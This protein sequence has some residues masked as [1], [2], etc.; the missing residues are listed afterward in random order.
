MEQEHGEVCDE[1]QGRECLL[2]VMYLG[3][4]KLDK[5]HPSKSCTIWSVE[6]RYLTVVFAYTY[7]KA[8]ESRLQACRDL[9]NPL[10]N[11]SPTK[12]SSP[13]KEFFLT[14]PQKSPEK[15]PEKDVL[16]ELPRRPISRPQSQLSNYSER[17]RSLPTPRTPSG[18]RRLT[19]GRP[20]SRQ[21][22]H[23]IEDGDITITLEN[24]A[25]ITPRRPRRSEHHRTLSAI[26]RPDSRISVH[27]AQED[28]GRTTPFKRPESA[29]SARRQS[30]IPTP[31]E[32]RTSGIPAPRRQSGIPT[33]RPSSPTRSTSSS[34]F[35]SDTIT[36]PTISNAVITN[37]SMAAPSLISTFARRQSG[38][39][40][41]LKPRSSIPAPRKSG[42]GIP[43]PR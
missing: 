41:I 8:L 19:F 17:Y 33:P 37:G 32:R 25:N 31:S 43:L 9:V 40:T 15:S 29:M 38:A 26:T 16:A 18:S 21:S 13:T 10:L 14:S 30:G 4:V 1:E 39:T 7:E 28:D 36:S 2:Q 24:S 34:S 5:L 42:S 23:E 11:S 12:D 3:Q 6:S 20:Q 22:E 27:S 35:H